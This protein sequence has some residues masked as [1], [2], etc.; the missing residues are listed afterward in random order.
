MKL[1]KELCVCI[2]S[3]SLLLKGLKQRP[4]AFLRG[5]R[6]PEDLYI[7]CDWDS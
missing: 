2:D 1:N 4:I 7:L 3:W 6:P 5:I